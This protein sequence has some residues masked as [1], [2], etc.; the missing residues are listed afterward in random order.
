MTTRVYEIAKEFSIESKRVLTTL[1]EMG[2]F[3]RSASSVVPD[4]VLR[5]LRE[6]LASLPPARPARP[7][8]SG[9]EKDGARQKLE[10]EGP[11]RRP[12]ASQWRSVP[13]LRLE[14]AVRPRNTRFDW[15]K[16]EEPKALTKFLLD[17][18]VVRFRDEDDLR[19]LK[20][21]KYF[22][23]EINHARKLAGHWG[24]AIFDHGWTYEQILTW[25]P[26]GLEVED[27]AALDRHGVTF[28]EL[29]WH[30]DDPGQDSLR[31]RLFFGR[32]TVDQVIL[33]AIARRVRAS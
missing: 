10:L 26:S 30:W 18:Y 11:P 14:A 3:V 16:G 17:H 25:V 22:V 31:Q 4:P 33:E 24:A 12:V 21:G 5:G 13:D 20:P 7:R 15:Y 28:S 2:E 6:R 1:K 27:A 32:M 8:T 19:H 23:R 29:D 9:R